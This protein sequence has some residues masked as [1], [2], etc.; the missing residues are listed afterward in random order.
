MAYLG[1]RAQ[2]PVWSSPGLV[3]PPQ[4]FGSEQAWLTYAALFVD[5]LMAYKS[6]LDAEL[7][8]IEMAGQLPM[9]MVQ[10]TRLFGATRLPGP[11]K[12]TQSY[13]D[14]DY[15]LVSHHGNVRSSPARKLL[16]S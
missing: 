2:L 16:P 5:S 13:T 9:D 12:D 8:P 15:I 7:V 4:T 1:Y 11:S 3:L 10:Y 14:S 6:R